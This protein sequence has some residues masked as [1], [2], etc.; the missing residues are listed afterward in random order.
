MAAVT[1]VDRGGHASPLVLV[2]PPPG[3]PRRDAAARSVRPLPPRA[4]A[5]ISIAALAVAA[6][7]MVLFLLTAGSPRPAPGAARPATADGTGGH[8]VQPGETYWSIAED[9]AGDGDVRAVV[10]HLVASTGGAPLQPGDVV[11]VAAAP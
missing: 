2:P 10:D 5:A 4:T 3:A 11:P 7:A 1:H 9:L 6:V 8:V